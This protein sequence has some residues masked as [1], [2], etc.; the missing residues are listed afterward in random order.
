MSAAGDQ[1]LAFVANTRLPS[2]RAQAL[3]V[4]QMAGAFARAG[5]DVELLHA[6]RRRTPPLPP[7]ADLW[8]HYGVPSGPR[9][10]VRAIPC[11]DW[12]ER[13]PVALQYVPARL[14]ELS[15]AR[16]AARALRDHAAGKHAAS[17]WVYSREIE[18][19]LHL[20]RAG[21]PHVFLE[22]HRVPG[23]RTRLRW[24]QQAARGV[25][26]VVAISGGVR[27]DLVASGVAAE[28]IR[29]EHDGYEATR[30]ARLPSR[31]AARE[32][33]RLPQGA[34]IVAYTG[35]LLEWKGVDVLVDAA[36]ELGDVLFVIA[37]GMAGDVEA[38]RAR[39]AGLANVRI[40]GFQPPERVPTYLAAADV[41]ALPNRA[42][43]AISARYTSPLK[44]FE[45]MAAGLPM[46]ASDLPALRECLRDDEARF[47]AADDPRALAAALGA[48]LA[49]APARARM[50]E[51]LLA[52]AGEH[53]WDARAQRIARW[54]R[55]RAS[56]R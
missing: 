11:S 30:F 44:L 7:G 39:A 42:R 28:R 37:G 13:V 5:L 40:D 18:C 4:V 10:R 6:K 17:T 3:Q 47:A 8:S 52:R 55:E 9:P 19:A 38:L 56:D 53:T 32:A 1:R 46:V 50:R 2:E 35:G 45:C 14:Q 20:V 26:G 31:E 51:R 21:A 36:R 12:I 43:P 16:N 15:F 23:G 25:R 33:L 29:V 48:L 49:D 22:V 41:A 34:S 24:L 27:D 54:M